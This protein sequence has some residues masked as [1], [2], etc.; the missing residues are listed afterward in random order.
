MTGAWRQRRSSRPTCLGDR[1]AALPAPIL[2]A[3]LL[4]DPLTQQRLA[5]AHETIRTAWLA[6]P[7][8]S[9]AAWMSLGGWVAAGCPHAA[10]APSPTP[11]PEA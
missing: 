7:F 11:C 6:L 8:T 9:P 4:Q 3:Q 10:A 2:A 5:A 1:P